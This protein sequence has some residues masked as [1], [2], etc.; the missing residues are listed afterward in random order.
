MRLLPREG[1]GVHGAVLRCPEQLIGARAALPGSPTALQTCAA[2]ARVPAQ[3]GLLG[4]GGL[5]HIVVT[6]SQP[7]RTRPWGEQALSTH[8][9]RGLL[10]ERGQTRTQRASGT[11][12][13]VTEVRSP[14]K[15]PS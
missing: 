11:L 15:S 8:D 13:N 4:A 14:R 7:G 9:S 6:R 5:G 3:R 12:R 10:G 2:G 1:L